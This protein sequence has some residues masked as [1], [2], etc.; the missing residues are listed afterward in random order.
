VSQAR[1]IL[2][3]LTE[4][5]GDFSPKEKELIAQG[6]YHVKDHHKFGY[7]PVFKNE[8]TG[9]Y[10]FLYQGKVMTPTEVYQDLVDNWRPAARDEQNWRVSQMKAEFKAIGAEV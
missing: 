2:K 3:A 4:V 8:E 5:E 6:Y 7:A 9:E 1:K 10:K